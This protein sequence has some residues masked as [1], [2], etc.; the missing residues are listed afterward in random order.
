MS[1]RF[2][3]VLLV[4]VLGTGAFL[5]WDAESRTIVTAVWT[6]TLPEPEVDEFEALVAFDP[7]EVREIELTVDA[8]HLQLR[9]DASGWADAPSA[10]VDYFLG[11]IARVGRIGS[12]DSED[13]ALGDFGLAPARRQ[14]VLR[15]A[16]A[17]DP[18]TILIGKANP[19]GTA[20]YTRIDGRGPVLIA[21][22]V[23]VWEFDRL[24]ERVDGHRRGAPEAR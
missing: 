8:L 17:G 22:S 10:F 12:I 21:G 20:V 3:W 4:L 9:R 5:L 18:L 19:P 14:I 13:G 11:N 7:N 15:G 16:G 1:A 23:L 2:T 6:G 24:V